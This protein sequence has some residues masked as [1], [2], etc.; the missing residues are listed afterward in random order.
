MTSPPGPPDD[1][2]TVREER[3]QRRFLVVIE[4]G[5]RRHQVRANM[6]AAS[7]AWSTQDGDALTRYATPLTGAYYVVPAS[8]ALRVRNIFRRMD[9]AGLRQRRTRGWRRAPLSGSPVM[10]VGGFLCDTEGQ[11]CR[12]A[13][14]HDQGEGSFGVWNP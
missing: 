5:G 14:E 13:S 1:E 8:E 11:G 10:N 3:R 4:L 9:H 2:V 6:W 7:T 12:S